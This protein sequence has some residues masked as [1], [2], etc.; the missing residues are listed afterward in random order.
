MQSYENILDTIEIQHILNDSMILE[1]KVKLDEQGVVNFSYKL[2]WNIQQK[3]SMTFNI[4]IPNQI[5]MRWIRGDTKPHI[6]HSWDHNTFENTY[7]IYLTDSDGLFFIGEDTYPIKSGYGYKFQEGLMHGTSHV[8]EDRLLIGPF[9]EHGVSVG[10]IGINYFT[11][12]I[13]DTLLFQDP[14]STGTLLSISEI[15]YI[16]TTP[17][18]PRHNPA[19]TSTYTIPNGYQ[20]NGWVYSSSGSYG[21]TDL[22]GVTATDGSSYP[23][24]SSYS[25][26]GGVAIYP[27]LGQVVCF[28][29][30]TNILIYDEETQQEIYRPI[31]KLRVN[32]MV[33][34][35]RHDY[36]KIAMIGRS[37][38]MNPSHNQ[39]IKNRLY[40][41]S[42]EMYPDLID[43]LY[44]T[45]SH[46][47]LVKEI[48][49]KEREHLISQ[50]KKIYV[51]EDR[52][53]LMTCVDERATP[54]EKEGLFNIYHFALEDENI[55]RNFGIYA[56]GLLVET[57]SQWSFTQKS[58][59]IDIDTTI[60]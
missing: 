54:W 5:P 36:K 31:E 20:Q 4:D 25:T 55:Y 40:R 41:L 30:G 56:N 15:N 1:N 47:I 22:N 37:E 19:F 44:M 34:T 43:D 11:S 53:R 49:P 16:N 35:Y 60:N 48:T 58:N 23:T 8:V 7:L 45:G 38:I 24:N 50:F 57:T 26:D 10:Y 14:T 33:K 32:D 46:A 21:T 2:P 18:D 42:E 39:R 51:T 6:D 3:L 59:F 52:Y 12:S 28:K 13:M 17:S 9:N 29:E 27:L